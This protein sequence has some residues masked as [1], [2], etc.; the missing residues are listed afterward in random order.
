MKLRKLV[1]LAVIIWCGNLQAV[2]LEIPE[3]TTK[4]HSEEY[5]GRYD[6]TSVTIPDSVTSIEE[7]AFYGCSGLTSVTIPDSVTSIG[8]WAFRDCSGLTSMTIPD[9]VMSIGN[10]AFSGC[11][12]LT[13]FIVAAG[14]SSYKSVNGL[15]LSKNGSTLIAG[16]NRD[17]AIPDG[18]TSIG[19]DAFYNCNGLTSV[20]IPDSVTS[21]GD[22]AFSGCSGLTRVTIGNGVTSIG[23]YVFYGCSGLTSVTIPDSVTSIGALAFGGCS[24]LTSVTIPNSVTR[25]DSSAFSGC[26][27][28]KDA[29]VPGR[30]CGISFGGVTNLVISAGTTSIGDSAFKGC[31][32][33]TSITIP[34]S[35]TSIGNSAFYN[36]SGLTS[37]TIPDSVEYIGEDAFPRYM[38]LIVSENNTH[39]KKVDNAIFSADGLI[40]VW[41]PSA[42]V[43]VLET[44]VRETDP[45]VLDVKYIINGGYD[46]AKV[47]ALAFEDGNRN[48]SKVVRPETFVPLADGSASITGDNVTCNV[49]NS[50]AWRVSSDY[51]NNLAKLRVEVFAQPEDLLPMDLMQLPARDGKP[52]LEFSYNTL[53]DQNVM[54]ALYWLYASGDPD[55]AL[56][57]GVL[58]NGNTQL[59]NG[60][61]LNG[62][63]AAQYVIRKMGYEPLTSANHL[64]YVNTET[65]LGL[66][67]NGTRQYAVKEI[68]E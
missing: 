57:N 54:N 32:G 50:F 11:S 44:S 26:D 19:N 6:I 64:N 48:W 63:N 52:A 33:L 30:R 12:G 55:L 22:S 58:K 65:R 10:G 40:Q 43:K 49:T 8:D 62:A 37:V 53:S 38:K 61:S 21:I 45:T 56:S 66:S 1:L 15:L 17:V 39:F 42:M 25:I 3:G 18:V 60:G 41:E 67:P 20:T 36:C 28:V 23:W 47:R 31:S 51:N 9:S 35:V 46:T 24:G 27:N 2:H 4:I 34:D 13:E 68:A 14:N 59:A 7:Y 16:I 29:T 5:F